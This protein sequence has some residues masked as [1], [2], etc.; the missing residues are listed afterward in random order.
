MLTL[1]SIRT[2][3]I[4]FYKYRTKIRHRLKKKTDRYKP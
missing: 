4:A 1:G 3:A 2:D